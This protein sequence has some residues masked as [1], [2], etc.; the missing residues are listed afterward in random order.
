MS[1]SNLEK[2]IWQAIV[3]PE[4]V[5]QILYQL[6]PVPNFDIK[7]L[8]VPLEISDDKPC[9]AYILFLLQCA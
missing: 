2:R 8:D 3:N 5:Q 4:R 1:A 7:R 6:M 9:L